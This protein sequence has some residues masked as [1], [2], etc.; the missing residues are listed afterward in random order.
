MKRSDLTDDAPLAWIKARVSMSAGACVE[1]AATR[2]ARLAMR[3]SKN[4]D[5][6]PLVSEDVA[7]LLRAA[8]SGQLDTGRFRH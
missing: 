5:Q 6:Q 2:S 8:R 3:D 7:L 1:M 4:I